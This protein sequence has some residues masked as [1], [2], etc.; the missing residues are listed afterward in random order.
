M[1]KTIDKIE[2]LRDEALDDLLGPI[3]LSAEELRFQVNEP[4]LDLEDLFPEG[5][6]EIDDAVS[7][8]ARVPPALPASPSKSSAPTTA[9]TTSTRAKRR[10]TIWLD[11]EVIE[12]FKRRA[13]KRGYQTLMARTLR[14]D[15]RRTR[16]ARA[17]VR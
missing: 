16:T 5:I 13:G 6:P 8:P 17:P 15:L 10:I 2:A 3:G 7:S 9:K 11:H 4:V 12:D 14:E 1:H